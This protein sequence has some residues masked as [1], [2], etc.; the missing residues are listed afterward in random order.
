MC[1]RPRR[2]RF[3]LDQA[4]N[5]GSLEFKT[6]MA[7][8]EGS[9]MSIATRAVVDV[10]PTMTIKGAAEAMTEHGF[11]RL[12]V[13]DPG[14][15]RLLGIIGSSDIIDFLGG[16]QKARL[17]QEKHR[18]NFLSAVNDSVRE[19]MATD[20]LTLD[21]GSKIKDVL[22]LIL[23]SRVGGVVILDE[24]RKVSGIVTERD[25]VFLLSGKLTG[26][27]VGD[28]MTSRVVVASPDMT[29]G[30]ATRAMVTNSFRR[31][32]VVEGK[33]LVG[34]LTTRDIIEFVGRNRAFTKLTGNKLDE[35][36]D[37]P[38]REIMKTQVA[39]VNRDTD[40][41]EVAR[42]IEETG[43]GT[44]CVVEDGDLKGILTER[45]IIKALSE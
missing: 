6:K 3:A 35:V 31:L 9:V 4:R 36:L 10:A 30:E 29:L 13:T 28:Y 11:R 15:K 40:L 22:G 39:R 34:M 19:I 23:D 16:G 8:K 38:A 20:V 1:L 26:K 33:E 27:K 17:V 24:E 43:T 25:L 41:G 37:T 14:T 32:P 18:G 42:I 5:R 44:V 7:E 21:K 45:D 12:P 2:D